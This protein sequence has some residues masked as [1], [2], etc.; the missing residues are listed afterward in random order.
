MNDSTHKHSVVVGLFVLFGMAI[1]V[2]GV[3]LLGNLNK[4]LQRRFKIVAYIEDVNGLQKGNY[5]WLS[6]VRIG[7]I[8][9]LRLRGT[10]GVEVV[11][12][13]DSKVRQ[14][15]YKDSRVKLGSDSFIGNRI[16]IVFGGTPDSGII[17]EGDTLQF[18]K[19]LSADD[20]IGTLQQNNENLKDITG[21]FKI[22]SRKLAEGEGTLGKLLNDESFYSN[23]NSAASSLKDA[24]DRAEQLMSSLADFSAGL[25]KQ[26][27]LAYEL[28]SDTLVFSSVRASVMR[29]R[30]IADTATVI[31]NHLKEAE[32]NPNSSVGVLLHDE[33]TGMNIR[34][35]IKNLETSSQKLNEDLEA[36]QHSF[37]MKG[38]FREKEKSTKKQ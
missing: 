23:I 25:K 37:L 29:L 18:E 14:Y 13:V 32:S 6:G 8:Y 11:M 19:T 30:E 9:S 34:G 16:L 2:S 1:L 35:I 5:I 26:G 4:S 21:D 17:E 33:A 15:I 27:T 24:S 36:L 12:D 38:Y 31:V 10:P 28:T 20:L 3:L 22:I 7:T